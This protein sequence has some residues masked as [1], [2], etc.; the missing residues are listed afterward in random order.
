MYDLKFRAF[1]IVGM[2]T[3]RKH[4]QLRPAN[5]QAA[6]LGKETGAGFLFGEEE[7]RIVKFVEMRRPFIV[8]GGS[9][10]GAKSGVSSRC[11]G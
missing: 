9:I 8:I 7:G 5:W 11:Q 1:G 10:F 2:N 4:C 3:A 6:V